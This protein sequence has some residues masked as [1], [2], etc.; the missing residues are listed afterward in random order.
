[1]ANVQE[2][3]QAAK[4]AEQLKHDIMQRVQ[5]TSNIKE[6]ELMKGLVD[7]VAT[8][9]ARKAKRAERWAKRDQELLQ[10]AAKSSEAPTAD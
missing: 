9:K 3:L 10:M 2:E 5:S 1:M 4:I 7:E 6:L 8:M